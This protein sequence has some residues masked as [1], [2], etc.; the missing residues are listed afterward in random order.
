MCKTIV[1]KLTVFAAGAQK[2]YFS[3]ASHTSQMN[4]YYG[5]VTEVLIKST[6]NTNA[7]AIHMKLDITAEHK[8]CSMCV[9]TCMCKSIGVIPL[10]I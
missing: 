1:K 8:R 5:Q 10:M 7:N 2:N 9:S 4:L 6:H 3:C